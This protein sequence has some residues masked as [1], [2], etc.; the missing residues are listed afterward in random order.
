MSDRTIRIGGAEVAPGERMTINLDA[1]TLYTHEP[2]YMPVHVIN[3]RRPGPVA[4]LAR[5][6]VRPRHS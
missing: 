3:G 1:G 4:R 6:S 5:H 2:V